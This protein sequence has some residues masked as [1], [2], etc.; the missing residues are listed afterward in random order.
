MF[1]F[2]LLIL[3]EGISPLTPLEEKIIILKVIYKVT[4]ESQD[5]DLLTILPLQLSTNKEQE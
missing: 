2:A 3:N 1:F 4:K 5:L